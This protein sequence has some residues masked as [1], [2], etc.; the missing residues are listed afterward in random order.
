MRIFSTEKFKAN[1]NR[2]EKKILAPFLKELEGKELVEDGAF[3]TAEFE[4]G[5][6]Y[7]IEEEW[8]VEI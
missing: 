4:D 6:I 1:S 2:F 3:Y 5:I 8:T 7:P